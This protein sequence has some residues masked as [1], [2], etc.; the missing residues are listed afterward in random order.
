M[1]SDLRTAN[2]AACLPAEIAGEE[3]EIPAVR[4]NHLLDLRGA[5]RLRAEHGIAPDRAVRG[6]E[7]D[8]RAGGNPLDGA[9]VLGVVVRGDDEVAGEI[10]PG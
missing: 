5:E 4:R 3:R 9:E 1:L 8:L 6:R 7:D 2:R 10:A